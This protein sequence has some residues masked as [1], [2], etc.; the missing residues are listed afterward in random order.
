[1]SR[2]IGDINK[3]SNQLHENVDE[4]IK[5]YTRIA[6]QIMELPP[7]SLKRGYGRLYDVIDE[8]DVDR[9]QLLD[10]LEVATS[11]LNDVTKMLVSYKEQIDDTKKSINKKIMDN[12]SLDKSARKVV[13]DELKD[14]QED[15]ESLPSD[16]KAII[17]PS[18]ITPYQGNGGKSKSKRPKSKRRKQNRKYTNRNKK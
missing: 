12:D 3:S 5:N 4:L 14:R 6:T 7:E 10:S 17:D 1:M 9:K 11:K 2:L 15:F 18:R 8:K 13:V 16:I